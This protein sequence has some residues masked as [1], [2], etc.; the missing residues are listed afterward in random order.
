MFNP[1]RSLK[2]R[3]FLVALV[4]LVLSSLGSLFYPLRVAAHP[5]A[6]GGM[7]LQIRAGQLTLKVRSS[8][9][10]I[11]VAHTLFVDR[12]TDGYSVATLSA[13]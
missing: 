12:E 5:V 3:M 6:L 9:E 11:C 4:S 8:M 1:Q 10:E 7:V 13:A 2:R